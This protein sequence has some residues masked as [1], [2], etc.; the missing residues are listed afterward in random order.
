MFTIAKSVRFM[1]H[2][3]IGTSIFKPK[4]VKYIHTSSN[5]LHIYKFY[6]WTNPGNHTGTSSAADEVSGFDV[7][8]ATTVGTILIGG[9]LI[10]IYKRYS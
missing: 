10:T 4:M 7:V 8:S 9:M 2:K 3:N 6:T 5:R 1:L